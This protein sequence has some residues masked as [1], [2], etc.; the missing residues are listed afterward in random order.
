MNTNWSSPSTNIFAGLNDLRKAL[1][2]GQNARLIRA[3]NQD[4]AFPIRVR[5]HDTDFRNYEFQSGYVRSRNEILRD[6]NMTD[7]EK[8]LALNYKTYYTSGKLRKVWE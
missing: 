5:H 2:A 6:P 4:C 3:R 8:H 1:A 7:F